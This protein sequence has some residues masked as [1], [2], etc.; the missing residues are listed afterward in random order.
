MSEILI[1]GLEMPKTCRRCIEMGISVKC[2]VI[3]QEPV[4]AAMVGYNRPEDCPLVELPPHGR[5]GDLDILEKQ[6]ISEAYFPSE[7]WATV[8]ELIKGASTV[9]EAS[10]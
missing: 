5:L 7:E 8:I 4:T 6:A 10:E 9:L 1:K 2:R 3:E